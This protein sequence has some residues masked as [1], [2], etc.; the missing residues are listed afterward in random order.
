MNETTSNYEQESNLFTE[1]PAIYASFWERLG[2]Y[3]IDAILLGIIGY[4]IRL[5]F[6]G[7]TTY[8]LD[9]SEGFSSTSFV[10]TYFGAAFWLTIIVDWLY[11]AVMESGSRQAT[12]GKMALGIKVTDTEGKRIS[13]VNATGRYFAKFISTI[14]LFI[15]FLMVLWDE[16]RQGLHD[17]L[18]GTL[19]AKG[20]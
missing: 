13:F 20:K 18:A 17:K 5:A 9:E 15:G 1:Q 12:L 11:F 8:V 6:G 3:I 10:A 2:A 14:I 16:R 19:V 4:M 7:D